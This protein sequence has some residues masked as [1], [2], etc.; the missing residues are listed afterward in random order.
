MA[1]FELALI[2]L[3]NENVL[4]SDEHFN[5][6]FKS[7][8]KMDETKS[9]THQI[10]SIYAHILMLRN[11]PSEAVEKLTTIFEDVNLTV[12]TLRMALEDTELIKKIIPD[13]IGIDILEKMI[14]QKIQEIS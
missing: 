14:R 6:C 8:L 5:L 9:L 2:S 4:Q 13:V 3:R 1:N 7:Y 10:N 11:K 12:Y